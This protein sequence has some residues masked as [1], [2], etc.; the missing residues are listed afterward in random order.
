MARLKD[1][2]EPGERVI[3]VTPSNWLTIPVGILLLGAVLT[4]ALMVADAGELSRAEFRFALG[5][6][7]VLGLGLT[8]LVGLM[9]RWLIAV[10]DRRVLFRHGF[11]RRSLEEM[12]RDLVEF[13]KLNGAAF[14]VHGG[15]RTVSLALHPLLADRVARLL[16][17]DY[18]ARGRYCGPFE[19]VIGTDER[20][21][22]KVGGRL[23][24]AMWII[25]PSLLIFPMV[26]MLRNN[27]FGAL[28]SGAFF[29]AMFAFTLTM[30]SYTY[31]RWIVTDR[32]V[33]AVVGLLKRRVEAMPL[34]S[35]TETTLDETALTI[36]SGEQTLTLPL[37][38]DPDKRKAARKIVEAIEAAKGAMP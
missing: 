34:T 33:L 31:K 9:T 4:T 1:M 14:E 12:P 32:R 37:A 6:M 16:D 10:T 24:V 5:F 8:I 17:A 36:R 21:L 25:M 13:I 18:A 38:N 7:A 15:G 28:L 20:I 22:V 35:D 11:M 19:R 27:V 30:L 2:L 23:L 26:V 3:A 29:F